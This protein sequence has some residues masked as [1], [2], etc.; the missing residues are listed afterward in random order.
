ML[1]TSHPLSCPA[2]AELLLL[3]DQLREIRAS[4]HPPTGSSDASPSS[5]LV[6]AG[7]GE[8]EVARDESGAVEQLGAINRALKDDKAALVPAVG[9]SRLEGLISRLT[10]LYLDIPDPIQAQD[11]S[12]SAISTEPPAAGACV[13][14]FL[15]GIR[16]RGCMP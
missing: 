1:S 16:C 9:L 10:L 14:N 5:P 11:L 6:P 8:E 4:F 13:A 2:Q 15:A 3:L 7:V 12:V